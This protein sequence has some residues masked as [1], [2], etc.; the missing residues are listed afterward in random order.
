M[1]GACIRGR[2]MTSDSEASLVLFTMTCSYEDY[3]VP[4]RTTLI[5]SRG[6][7]PSDLT[8]FYQA[9]PLKGSTSRNIAT[10]G[11]KL[12]AY[13]PLG[14]NPKPYPNHRLAYSNLKRQHSYHSYLLATYTS[15]H[16]KNNSKRCFHR[17]LY[18]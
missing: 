3:T 16:L 4:T 1:V 8:T 9:P 14:D 7:A 2:Y 11:T 18:L 15:V 12:P 17:S 5:F 6:G 10:L 13:E